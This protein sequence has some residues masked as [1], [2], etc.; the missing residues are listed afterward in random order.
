V[1]FTPATSPGLKVGLLGGSFNPAHEGHRLVST[2]S[3]RQLGLDQVWWL[4][5]PQNPLK[6]ESG[7]APL[8]ERLEGAREAAD[9]PRII[10]TDIENQ[11]GTRYTVDTVHALQQRFRDVRFVWL[12]GADNMIQLPKW[13]KWHE[14]V[15]T[16]PIA[17]YPRPGFTLK[18][19]LSP[20]ASTY[21]SAWLDGS[22]AA[23]LSSLA[24]PALCFLEGPQDS[25]SAT[26]IRQSAT[27]GSTEKS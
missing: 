25:I 13:S 3:M 18:A 5:S 10:I 1:P 24:A 22:D 20:A 17:I 14:L 9:H 11:L 23:L 7:M 19:R 8:D 4:V 27:A 12:M 6:P 16:I 15:D 21:R 26:S 2:M